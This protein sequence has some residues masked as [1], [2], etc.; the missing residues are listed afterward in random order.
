MNN[1][2]H[3]K[4]H[5][6]GESVN[7]W[8]TALEYLKD[9]NKRYVE[10]HQAEREVGV[11]D[12][13]NMTGGQKPYSVI[14]T[15]SDSRVSPELVFDAGFGDIFVIRN[16]GNIVDSTVLGCIEYAVEHLKTPLIAVVGHSHCGAVTG[17]LKS[18]E[19]PENLQGI[20]DAIRPAI[21]S[22]DDLKKATHANVECSVERI[23]NNAVVAGAKVKVIG[24][25]YDIESGEVTFKQD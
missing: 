17:A 15:C 3:I 16:A 12:R 18:G 10:N 24:A 22:C 4:I 6:P 19:F 11:Q 14:L 13:K 20:I 5:D 1:D 2:S 8:R 9:G 23:K 7:D 21:A 25:F